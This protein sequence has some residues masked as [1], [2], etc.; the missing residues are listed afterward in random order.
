MRSDVRKALED[1]GC[2]E[3]SYDKVLVELQ[4]SIVKTMEGLFGLLETKKKKRVPQT[5]RWIF[6]S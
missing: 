1:F 5:L 4:E 2:F 6:E 3:A